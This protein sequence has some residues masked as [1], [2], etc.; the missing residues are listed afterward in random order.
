MTIT[1]FLC[2]ALLHAQDAA[3]V[4]EAARNQ[5][6]TGMGSRSRMV[7]T[8][9][10]GSTQERVIDQY[11]KDDPSGRFRIVIVFQS[12]ESVKDTRFL[13]V[14][15]A[16]GKSDQW[17]FLPALGKIHHIASSESSGVF[18][19]TDFSYDD[20]SLTSRS[21]GDDVHKLLRQENF[22]GKACYVIESSP[23]DK[24]YQYS[25]TISWID[26][27]NNLIYKIE[28]Y[29]KKGTLVK[30]LELSNYQNRQGRMAPIQ[31][32]IST[33]AAGTFT[34]IFMD[35]VQYDMNDRELSDSVFS[36]NFLETGRS[37]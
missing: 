30:V 1:V 17:I 2:A 36:T 11:S 9:K 28:L 21:V 15:K 12:P 29:D 5:T 6:R 22:G 31:I 37:Q 23:K 3:A 4:M 25:K 16:G 26:A 14:G 13:T 33:V 18:M 35:R 20:L 34:T 27:A 8:A 32:K 7:I 10:N 24:S 19:G